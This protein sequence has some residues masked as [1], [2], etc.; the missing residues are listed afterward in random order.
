[1]ADTQVLIV[2]AG[3][4]GVMAARRLQAEGISVTVLDKGRSV[5]GRMATRRLADGKADTGAQ[6]FTARTDT[7]KQEISGW[8]E[9][10][11][12]R[13][14]GHGWSDGSLKRTRGDGHPRYVVDGGMN[15]LVKYLA[16]DLN[17]V[18]VNVKIKNIQWR[19]S[20]WLLEDED[21]NHYSGNVLLL[22]PPVP[23][24]LALLAAGHITLTD[25][26]QKAL[27]RIDYGPCLCGLF[28]VDGEVNLPDPGAMQNFE[29]TVYWLADNERK[30]ISEKRIITIHAEARY[31]RQHYDAPDEEILAFLQDALMPYLSDPTQIIESQ[32]KKWRYSVPLTTH[33]HDYLVV[34]NLPAV[35]AGDAFGGRGRVEGAFLSGLAAADALKTLLA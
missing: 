11:L 27:Q 30:G 28:V 33:P 35:F 17:D 13:V 10:G 25:K 19:E 29:E 34:E 2:G 24:S 1:M 12:V 22:T 15:A 31:S 21:G 16:A 6:F 9:A 3:L 5:G 32:L 26:D 14:W 4:S 7:L 8:Q 20:D 23:Q 18:R